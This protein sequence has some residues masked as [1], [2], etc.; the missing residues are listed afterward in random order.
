MFTLQ[1]FELTVV[2]GRVYIKNVFK[3]RI[4]GC[5]VVR[6]VI[7]KL[8]SKYYTLETNV[9]LVCFWYVSCLT[10]TAVFDHTHSNPKTSLA[11]ILSLFTL[12][13]IGNIWFFYES[14]V[15]VYFRCPNS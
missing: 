6:N 5:A 3:I 9:T 10:N 4:C 13:G 7:N 12:C 14:A 8:F 11:I 1:K 2:F 15:I